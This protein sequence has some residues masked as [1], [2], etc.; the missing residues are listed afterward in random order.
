MATGHHFLDTRRHEKLSPTVRC[1]LPV[2]VRQEPAFDYTHARVICTVARG[3]ATLAFLA[4]SV[5]T[6]VITLPVLSV[7][8]YAVDIGTLGSPFLGRAYNSIYLS[9]TRTT[10]PPI[11]VMPQ[12]PRGGSVLYF[13]SLACHAVVSVSLS[14]AWDRLRH[15]ALR[16]ETTYTT[17][18]ICGLLT[19]GTALPAPHSCFD[20]RDRALSTA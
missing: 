8:A 15:S 18:A 1:N 4:V 10:P 17:A 14:P 7:S 11:S 3:I 20:I 19:D 12:P 2:R 16:W 5:K 6:P 9:A 13:S